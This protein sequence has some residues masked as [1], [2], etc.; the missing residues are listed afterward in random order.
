MKRA[1]LLF[2]A[3]ILLTCGMAQAQMFDITNPGDTL[4]GVPNDNNWPAAETPPN[5]IDNNVSTKY[6]CFKTS[7]VPD[8]TTG[9]SG[10]CVTPSGPKVVVKALNFASANDTPDRDP[11]AFSFWGSDDSISGPWTLIANG[12][13]DQ[14]NQATDYARLTW[15][16]TPVPITNKKAYTHYQLLFTELHNRSAANSMQIAEVELL[17]DGSK[18]GAA[19]DPVPVSEA[20]DVPRD[21][22]MSWAAGQT[23]ATHDVYFGTNFADVNTASRTD[24]KGVL[25]SKDQTAAEFDP[26]GLLEY[27]Q[28]YYWRVDEVNAAPDNTIF[29]GDVWTF[30]AEPYAYPI[31]NIT[32]TASSAQTD[33]GPENTINGSGLNESDEHSTVLTDAWM[34]AGLL[35]NWIQYEFDKSYKLYE[36]WVWNSNQIIEPFIGFGPKSVTIEY[37]TDGATWTV[38]EGTPEFAKGTGLATYTHNTT[39]DLGGVVAKF[40][41]LTVNATWGGLPQTGLS[42]VRFLYVPVQAYEPAPA[43]DAAEVSLSAT[44]NWRPGREAASHTVYFGSDSE[45]V[46]QGT[47]TA[48]TVTGH[49]FTPSGMQYGVEY[50]WKIDEVGDAGAYAGDVWS[51]TAQEFITAEDFE[52]YDDEANRIFDVWI[53]G[54]TTG[55]SGSQ[56]GYDDAPFAEK[57]IVHGGAQSMPMSYNNT[58]SPYVSEAERTFDAAQNWTSNGATEICIWTQGYPAPTPVA[59]AETNGKISVTGAGADIWNNSD[60]F[61][62]AYKTLTGDGSIIAR[63]V[64]NGTGTN[65]WAKGGVMIRDSINGG[66][67]HATMAIT[68]SAGNGASFQYRTT[69]DGASSNSDSTAVVAPPYWAKVER[70]GDMFTGYVSADGKT[71]TKIGTATIT[72]EDPVLIGLPVTSH[73]TGEDRTY[74]FDSITT[75]GTVTGAWQGAVID[76]ALYN[77]P[78]TLYVTVTDSAGKSATATSDTAALTA[79]WTRWAIPMTNF[80]GVNFAKVQD[81]IIGV[82]TKGT[83]GGKGMVFIDD[84]GYGKSAQ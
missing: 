16:T 42:E 84:I 28:T 52:S 73:Q 51:F 31:E 79:T 40:V 39:V 22:A 50:F 47:A 61:T 37:S 17:S 63:V 34:S 4:V 70:S 30:T 59:V 7:F 8:Q 54:L 72:M 21:A 23:A 48:K 11:V 38:L 2:V 24:A 13:I 82:G 25:I 44:L 35:P 62:Y 45:A 43:D 60:E 83:A 65:T 33:M 19:G 12:T 32:A 64:S 6:L 58:A 9:Y 80:A 36:L 75:T 81:I 68:G 18:A 46:A 26:E 53:D 29:R 55:A 15:I 56:V 27:G 78:A 14:F 69:T 41:K 20:V 3:A 66:S 77:D 67:T 5:A 57:T 74:Q 71:W 76:K 1:S 49:T 10:F